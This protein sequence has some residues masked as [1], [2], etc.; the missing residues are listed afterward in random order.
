[1]Q[2]HDVVIKYIIKYIMDALA[3]LRRT[4]PRPQVTCT[5]N[6]VKFEHVVFYISARADR[7]TN[8][9]AEIALLCTHS[10]GVVI[11]IIIR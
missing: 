8:T 10:A 1:M 2:K 11:I 3:K 7:Q 9:H 4:E 6:L 5:K